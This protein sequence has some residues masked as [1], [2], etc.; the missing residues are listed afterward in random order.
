VPQGW[1]TP[2]TKK[3]R[4]EQAASATLQVSA[5][6]CCWGPVHVLLTRTVPAAG[7]ADCPGSG[8]FRLFWQPGACAAGW[9]ALLLRFGLLLRTSRAAVGVSSP[10]PP[11]PNRTL[12][13]SCTH[14]CPLPCPSCVQVTGA[15]GWR[16]DGIRYKKNEVFLDVIESVTMLM[17]ATVRARRAVRLTWSSGCV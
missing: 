15:V 11:F 14:P 1:V 3:K 16:R 5:A 7:T 8:N 12:C 13:M 10:K 9:L 17:S 2:A 6:C 4:E